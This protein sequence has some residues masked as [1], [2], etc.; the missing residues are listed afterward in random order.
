VVDRMHPA[1]TA[2]ID[3]GRRRGWIS[4]EELND[5]LPDEYVDLRHVT[6]LLARFDRLSIELIDESEARRRGGGRDPRARIDRPDRSTGRIGSESRLVSGAPRPGF[7]DPGER[8][9]RVESW[10]LL[11]AEGEPT[12]EDLERS[13]FGE[14]EEALAVG[15]AL[16]GDAGRAIDDPV[17]MYFSQMGSIELL[18]REEEVRLA[19]KIETTRLIF[20]LRVLESDYAANQA[21][22]VLGQV[23]RGE[24]AVDRTLRVSTVA[25]N[26]R[27]RLMRRVAANLGTTQQLIRLSAADFAAMRDG[28]FTQAQERGVRQMMGARRRRV[29]V[30][31]EECQLRT[32]RI[33][34]MLKKLR[35]ICTKM[36]ELQSELLRVE[37]FPDRYDPEDAL[38]IREELEGLCELVQAEPDELA[39]RLRL[40]DR[41]CSEYE[42]AKRDLSCANLRLVISI[43]KRYRNRGVP[44]LDLIQEGNTG[45]MRAVDKY[46]YK[47][48]YKFST[49]ATWW[50]RQSIT[51]SISETSRTVRVPMHMLELVS[52]LR[53]AAKE[54]LQA[55]G[56]EPTVEEL[57]ERTGLTE[58]EVRRV[59][60]VGRSPVSLDRAIGDDS[61]AAV[62]D[63][64]EDDRTATPAQAASHDALRARIDNV[65]KTLTYREREIIKLRFGIGDGYIY[66]LEEVGRIFKVTRERVRQ[67]EARAIRK[68]QHPVRSRKFAGFIEE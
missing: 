6:E 36:Q 44:F 18:T 52:K 67:V 41:V 24:Q 27:D 21:A 16:A 62:G 66:T 17:R 5:C 10:P 45:L 33:T 61:S 38:G 14:D 37:K 2:L 7:A 26:H 30:L 51:R 25:E 15:V 57:A 63:F 9:L 23:S 68:L 54:M 43:A 55:T 64:I 13:E 56:R 31:I 20:R 49:Y 11:T 34:P 39:A 28:C 12:T 19:K 42:Q 53:Y 58:D 3:L 1:V 8:R 35:S 4:Y 46:E 59:I 50:I 29:A 32:S 60:R 40:V 65:L 47:R 22:D 48:G